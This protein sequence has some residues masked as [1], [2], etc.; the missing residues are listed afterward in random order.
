MLVT[1]QFRVHLKCI[2]ENTII[3]TIISTPHRQLFV[4]LQ[5]PDRLVIK[6]VELF[7]SYDCNSYMSL[8]NSSKITKIIHC[9]P[10]KP[11][12][13][14]KI[15]EIGGAAHSFGN[16]VIKCVMNITYDIPSRRHHLFLFQG[17]FL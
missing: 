12:H 10:E 5:S 1:S 11:L 14:M 15:D 3:T 16:A 17:A 6:A 13:Q 7:K 9:P 2:S 4:L 8:L